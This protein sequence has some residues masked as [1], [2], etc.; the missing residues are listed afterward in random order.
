ME[1]KKEVERNFTALPKMKNL[2]N[3]IHT[4]PQQTKRLLGIDYGSLLQL[5]EQAHLK[6][7]EQQ[8][9][10]ERQKSRINAKG[11]GRKPRSGV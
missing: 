11:G 5:L 8:A 7:T 1:A 4:Y 6:H 10:V 3:Y 2:L 9:E